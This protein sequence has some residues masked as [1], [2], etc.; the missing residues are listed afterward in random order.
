MRATLDQIDL[1]TRLC[2]QYPADFQLA[3]SAREI[4]SIIK[5]GK[6]AGLIGVE[7][8]HSIDSSLGALRTFFALGV[9][10]VPRPLVSINGHCAGGASGAWAP[11]ACLALAH[12]QV[13]TP[14]ML[15]HSE[16][17]SHAATLLHPSDDDIRCSSMAR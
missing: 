16:M 15:R 5:A 11:S 8:G 13:S 7:G 10:C 6:I 17:R 4:R 12:M 2:D 3:T 14:P 1:I 9:R